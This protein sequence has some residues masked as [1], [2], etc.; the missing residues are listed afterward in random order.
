MKA[1]AA[2]LLLLWLTGCSDYPGA[3]NE[4]TF[5]VTAVLTGNAT[6]SSLAISF[7]G[8][9]AFT[10]PAG[11]A[12]TPVN[13]SPAGSQSSETSWTG[14][15]DFSVQADR[16]LE[17]RLEATLNSGEELTLRISYRELVPDS[18][19][20]ERILYEEILPYSSSTGNPVTISSGKR[21][22]LP[23]AP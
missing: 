13:I 15:T 22:L 16:F 1:G 17:S 23:P 6:A 2:A 12:W 20:P 18:L 5:R 21:I 3:E 4:R 11:S 19:Y 8:S 9:P 10:D 14:V 7:T